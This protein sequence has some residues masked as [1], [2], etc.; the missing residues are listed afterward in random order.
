MLSLSRISVE[1][2]A[3]CKAFQVHG[4]IAPCTH[5]SNIH[6]SRVQGLLQSHY[7]F[8]ALPLELPSNFTAFRFFIRRLTSVSL[9]DF[10]K[11]EYIPLIIPNCLINIH[12]VNIFN[13]F[14][15]QFKAPEIKY[16]RNMSKIRILLFPIILRLTT[17]T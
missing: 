13:K 1:T 7:I 4:G 8:P 9:F 12:L 15:A 10:I 17:S 6:H 3:S 16:C 2:D 11:H 14:P 5:H